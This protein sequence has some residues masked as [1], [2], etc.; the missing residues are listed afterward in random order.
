MTKMAQRINNLLVIFSCSILLDQATKFLVL[1]NMNQYSSIKVIDGLFNITFVT[2]KGMAFGILNRPDYW[3][4]YFF[5][6][7]GIITIG[8]L[9]WWYFTCEIES[10]LFLYGLPLVIGGAVGNLIDRSLHG[11][12]IDFLDLHIGTLHW[13]AFNV[14]DSCITVGSFMLIALMAFFNSTKGR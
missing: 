11:Y 12:V 6:A 8:G 4:N 13:P 3:I 2:N 1:N 14:A 5:I 7:I 10:R 9:L